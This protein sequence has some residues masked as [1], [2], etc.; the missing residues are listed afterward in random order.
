MEYAHRL[1]AAYIPC[2]NMVLPNLAEHH[3]SS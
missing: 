1:I 3:L 2:P